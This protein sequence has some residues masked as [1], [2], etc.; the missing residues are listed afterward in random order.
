MS[1]QQISYSGPLPPAHELQGY[2]AAC[3]GLAREIADMAIRQ[4]AH[5]HAL[6]N[7]AQ[8]QDAETVRQVIQNEHNEKKT[9]QFLAFGVV[10][11]SPSLLV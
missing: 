1:T 7:N 8:Q 11:L 9:G 2:E 4:Q 10:S 6:E 3:S 5:R